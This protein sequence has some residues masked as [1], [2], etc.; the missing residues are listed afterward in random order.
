MLHTPTCIAETIKYRDG[1]QSTGAASNTP[2]DDILTRFELR[3]NFGMSG[4]SGTASKQMAACGI[5]IVKMSE[6]EILRIWKMCL[7]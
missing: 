7:K 6:F 3:L 4:Q 2:R 5:L 1:K